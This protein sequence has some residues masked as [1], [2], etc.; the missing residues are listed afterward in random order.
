MLMPKVNS[1]FAIMEPVIAAFTTSMSPALS[2]KNRTTSSVM[3]QNVRF[4]SAPSVMPVCLASSS[5][6]V[7]ISFEINTSEI[8]EDIKIDMLS[9]FRYWSRMVKEIRTK[10]IFIVVSFKIRFFSCISKV[11]NPITSF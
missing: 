11:F 7:P 5:V 3:F 10:T 2:A 4:N 6:A 1:R 9:I 8:A